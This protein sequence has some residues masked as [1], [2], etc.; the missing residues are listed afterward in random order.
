MSLD[1]VIKDILET[2]KAEARKIIKEGQAEKAKQTKIAKDEGQKLMLSKTKESEDLLRRMDTQEVARAELE[3]KKIV[4]SS[5]KELLDAVYEKALSR[6][7]NLPQNESLLR[8][9]VSR[10][11]YDI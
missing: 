8:S 9:L 10:N 6:M 5:Q 3:S 4:L 1:E 11:Q 2:G 7:R